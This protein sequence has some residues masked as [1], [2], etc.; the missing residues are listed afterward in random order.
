MSVLEAAIGWLAPPHCLTCGAEG[1]ALC[2]LCSSSEIIPH[3]SRC[4]RCGSLSELSR[5]CERC[6]WL[7]SPTQVW[8][9][10]DYENTAKELISLYKFGHLRAAAIPLASLM[11]QTFL[12]SNDDTRLSKINYLVAPVP[13]A[14]S[15]VRQR[16]FDHTK[17]LAKTISQHL[18]FPI[19]YPLVRI[20]QQRQVGTKRSDRLAQALS[21]Y[22]V[23][24]SAAVAGRNILLID[25]VVTTGGTIIA[26]T[27]ALR[28]AGAK[29]VDA[30]IFAKKL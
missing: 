6:R 22:K 24:D 15:R 28:A 20:G 14:S 4:W 1:S 30:L 23:K 11:G 19:G 21:S 5:T 26:A 12:A 18:G 3:G 25:D 2:E 10:T 17:L 8:I 7:G 29:R 16:G 9:T 13:T 27:K